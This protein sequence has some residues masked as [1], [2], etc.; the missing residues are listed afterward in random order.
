MPACDVPSPQIITAQHIAF[1]FSS[2]GRPD[3]H[4]PTSTRPG[5]A[6]PVDAKSPELLINGN[7]QPLENRFASK[8]APMATAVKQQKRAARACDHCRRKRLKCSNDIGGTKCMNCVLYDTECEYTGR[9]PPEGSG[10]ARKRARVADAPSEVN[11]PAKEAV[12]AIPSSANQPLP[13]PGYTPPRHSPIADPVSQLPED[14][15]KPAPDDIG[16]IILSSAVQEGYSIEKRRP[17]EHHRDHL[18]KELSGY[19]TPML[20]G[21]EDI[22][23]PLPKDLDNQS[24]KLASSTTVDALVTAFFQNVLPLYPI[25]DEANFRLLFQ[26]YKQKQDIG[27]L[28]PILLRLVLASGAASCQDNLGLEGEDSLSNFRKALFAQALKATPALYSKASTQSIQIMLLISLYSLQVKRTN[29][30]WY[31]CGSAIRLAQAFGIYGRNVRAL[32]E[33]EQREK[34][35]IAWTAFTME[36]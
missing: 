12:H 8:E 6:H 23:E 20:T 3:A 1:D 25:L 35:L 21:V 15:P 13:G 34:D 17:P 28:W 14:L 29:S 30:A 24:F 19:I 4:P 27:E 2:V 5:E 10:N 7:S 22:G 33:Q 31:W 16:A 26:R 9:P 18:A 11:P 36:T 32:N